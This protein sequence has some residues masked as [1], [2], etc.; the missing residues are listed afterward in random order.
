MKMN[1]LITTAAI[2]LA[3]AAFL[4]TSAN[5][6]SPTAAT[7]GDLILGFQTASGNTGSADNLE[8][9]LGPL[10]NFTANNGA[11]TNLSSDFTLGDLDGLYKNGSTEP[12]ALYFGAFG[13]TYNA[14]TPNNEIT[15]TALYNASH[16]THEPD[17]SGTNSTESGTVDGA[18]GAYDN[19]APGAAGNGSADSIVL[20][21]TTGSY[22]NV[23]TFATNTAA[24]FGGTFPYGTDTLYSSSGT[25]T[26]QVYETQ[27]TGSGV[28]TLLGTLALTVNDVAG[29]DSLTFTATG[30]AAPEPSTYALFGVSALV[31]ILAIRRRAALKA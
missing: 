28:G 1:K 30:T 27:A 2:V 26:L 14:E 21:G 19:G 20:S 23:S 9:D 8:I 13:T 15:V 11:V 10:S 6:Q 31:M 18:Y 3:G 4:H 7:A 12:T 17:N 5:A 29:T 25:E 24:T 22:T 16:P